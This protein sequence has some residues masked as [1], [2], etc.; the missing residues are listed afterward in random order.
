MTRVPSAQHPLVAREG[1]G[2]IGVVL[3]CGLV[4]YYY[5][6]ALAALPVLLLAAALAFYFRDP[7]RDSPSLPLGVVAPVDGL[8]I[9]AGP[10]IDPWLGREALCVSVVMSVLDVHSIF[11]PTEGKIVEQWSEARFAELDQRAPRRAFAYQL[12]TDEGDDVTL[13]IAR[14]PVGGPVAI[15]YQP[16]ERVGHGR[17]I[18]FAALGCRVTVYAAPGTALEVGTGVQVAAAATVV[19]TLVH[20]T[21]VSAIPRDEGERSA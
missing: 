10:A 14:G 19:A 2:P 20:E 13:E 18:G 1:R 5:H 4:V 3:L 17:R 16:G 11:S 6:G 7:H 21:P 9:H 15:Y 12:R 8:V